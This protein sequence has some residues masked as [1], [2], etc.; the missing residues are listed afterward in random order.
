MRT[1]DICSL[2]KA[3]EAENLISVRGLFRGDGGGT[4]E[5]RWGL[6]TIALAV[7]AFGLMQIPS[8][9]AEEIEYDQMVFDER[10]DISG[11]SW[12]EAQTH[13]EVDIVNVAAFG[14]STEV[15]FQMEMA[16]DVSEDAVYRLRFLVDNEHEVVLEAR[17]DE[18][19][20][21]RDDRNPDLEVS[22][23][24]FQ[25]YVKWDVP[26]DDINATRSMIFMEATAEI[27]IEE[28]TRYYDSCAWDES[29][30]WKGLVTIESVYTF[31]QTGKVKRQVKLDYED[32]AAAGFRYWIDAD[33]D[34]YI[35]QDELDQYIEQLEA[36]LNWT[37]MSVEFE[38]HTSK[39]LKLSYEIDPGP[40]NFN[41]V[42]RIWYN[43]ELEYPRPP[44]DEFNVRWEMELSNDQIPYW[45]A[46]PGSW[47]RVY[48]QE[49]KD[50]PDHWY[51]FGQWD[52]SELEKTFYNANFTTLNM[53]STQMRA[54][55]NNTMRD[56]M[57]FTVSREEK[58]PEP[59]DSWCTTTYAI[60]V[61]P[62]GLVAFSGWRGTGR[63]HRT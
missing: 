4:L 20:T 52:M 41:Y 42:D 23:S 49:A 61:V 6:M 34:R 36:D 21:G 39:I 3:H 53:N 31:H 56:D 14:K 62:A 7:A 38:Q 46:K 18:N 51:R 35:T 5:L 27:T 2:S 26:L 33:G 17:D 30:L 9:C 29:D 10:S 19:I 24:M 54:H 32:Q 25:A 15:T 58:S 60:M 63:R 12:T 28:L 8:A 37:D 50:D 13:T 22:G 57:G 45:R 59:G 48:I 44:R 55:W 16:G 47:F 43:M 1:V 11:G 40:V